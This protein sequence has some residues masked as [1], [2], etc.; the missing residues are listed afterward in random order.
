[1]LPLKTAARPHRRHRPHRRPAALHSGQLRRHARAIRSRRWTA[2]STVPQLPHPLC[3]GLHAG[4]RRGRPVPRTAF[5]LQGLKTEFFATPD[6]TGR[7][8]ATLT[9]PEVQA[10]WE[11]A[12]PC[13]NWPRHNYSVRWSGSLTVPR[14]ATT[15]SPSNRRQL[16]LLARESYRFVLDGKVISE[17][18]LRQA[19]RPLVMGNFTAAPGASPTAP[20]RKTTPR[21][22]PSR[23][24]SPTPSPMTSAWSTRTLA[25]KPAADSPS[26][27]KPPRRRNSTKPWPAPK[28]LMW[29]LPS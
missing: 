29:W 23:S 11:N 12:C 25:T 27:G 10:D 1:V 20:P 9:Q 13:P 28:K 18:S 26:S 2:S 22:P 17:G 4:R 6:W 14:P 8:V 7:P 19:Q 15:S 21:H 16:P 24:I 5:G 3:A